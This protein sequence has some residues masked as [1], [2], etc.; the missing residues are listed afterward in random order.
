MTKM[1]KLIA[2]FDAR[3]N[4]LPAYG[5][6]LTKEY[7]ENVIGFGRA[8]KAINDL[9]RKIKKAGAPFVIVY[10]PAKT[11]QLRRTK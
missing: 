9:R 5:E 10:T 1:D 7:I 6:R 2:A 4:I 11:Y 8:K 3:L